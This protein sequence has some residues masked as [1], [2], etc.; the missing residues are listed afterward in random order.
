M[1]SSGQRGENWT[2]QRALEQSGFSSSILFKAERHISFL[3]NSKGLLQVRMVSH[4]HFPLIILQPE[5]RFSLHGS[6]PSS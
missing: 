5:I 3:E 4:S 2:S 6:K 1:E